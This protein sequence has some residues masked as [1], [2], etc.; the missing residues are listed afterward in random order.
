LY[1]NYHTQPHIYLTNKILDLA[2]EVITDSLRVSYERYLFYLSHGRQYIYPPESNSGLF[3][4]TANYIPA[5]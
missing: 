4:T 3:T 1:L 5:T 2:I